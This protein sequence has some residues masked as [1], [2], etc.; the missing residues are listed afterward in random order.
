MGDG[1][2]VGQVPLRDLRRGLALGGSSW[3]YVMGSEWV[4]A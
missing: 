2:F 4:I 1:M 3:G